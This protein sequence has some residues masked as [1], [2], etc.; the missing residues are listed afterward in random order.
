[1]L[2]LTIQDLKKSV[3]AF[4][5]NISQTD[6]HELYGV[7]DGKAVGTYVEV[8]FNSYLTDRFIYNQ[9]SA[10]TGIDFPLLNIDLKVTSIR[11]PQSSCPFRSAE[12]KVYGLG[13]DLLVLVYD[14]R[15]DKQQETARLDI[16]HAVFVH[17]ERT[18]DFQ[19][20]RGI[21]DILSRDANKDDL[22]AFFE[23]R[24]L[25]LEEIGR[26]SLAER[27]LNSPPKQGYLTISNA[28]QW[29]LQYGRVITVAA[30]G[31]VEGVEN[32]FAELG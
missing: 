25:P 2:P 32:V 6:I 17:K 23:E 5:R 15:D 27:V 16:Q 4:T 30:E 10:A 24:N 20:T 14:K 1:M 9:G 29:R 12:Q 7:T 22:V 31:G 19:T 3:Y 26:Q 11:Q 21:L 28:L 8:L 18:A 13:Y